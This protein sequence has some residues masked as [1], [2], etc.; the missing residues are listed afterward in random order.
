MPPALTEKHCETLR[1]LAT[2]PLD[3]YIS[4]LNKMDQSLFAALVEAL[5]NIK[6]FSCEMDKFLVA[7]LIGQLRMHPESRGK[8]LL[9]HQDAIQSLLA[10]VFRD[11][12]MAEAACAVMS[13][14]CECE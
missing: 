4:I 3:E 14:G 5:L 11:A 2:A 6:L 7:Y 1:R 8:I 12:L 13:H 9:K 10:H